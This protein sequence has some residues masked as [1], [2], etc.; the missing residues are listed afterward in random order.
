MSGAMERSLHSSLR[1]LILVIVCASLLIAAL[2]R[3]RDQDWSALVWLASTVLMYAIRVPHSLRNRVNRIVDRR[4]DGVEQGLL[5]GMFVTMMIAPMLHLAT[6]LFD[7]ADYRLPGW[8]TVLGAAVQ[9]VML[10][11]FWRSHADLG[12]NWSPGLEVREDHGLVTGGVYARIRHPMYAAIWLAALSQPLLLQ[13]WIAGPPVILA[14]ALMWLV[15]L[16]RE[17]AMMRDRF[18]QAYWDYVRVTGRV[19]PRWRRDASSA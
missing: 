4:V 19:M 8:A 18:G 1:A 14:F 5:L 9:P 3:S 13:N 10:W 11:L 7:F 15:R 12:R 6:G 16:P 2:S 17:E